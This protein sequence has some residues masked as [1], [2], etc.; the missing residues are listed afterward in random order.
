MSVVNDL[1]SMMSKGESTAFIRYLESRNKRN[2]A[3]NVKHF[4][5]VLGG[6]LTE[7][8]GAYYTQNS[9]LKSRLIEFHSAKV[10]EGEVSEEISVIKL[11][12]VARKLFKQER[13][14]SAFKLLEAAEQAALTINHF[15]LLQEIYH[16]F[17][18]NSHLEECKDRDGL[19]EKLNKNQSAIINSEKLNLAFATVKRRFREYQNQGQLINLETIVS[20]T[21][22]ELQL[23]QNLI[24]NFQSLSQLAEITDIQGAYGRS[25]HKVNLFFE[26]QIS[27]L[28]DS[29]LDT[30]KHLIYHI[31]LLYVMGSTYFRK[32]NFQKAQYYVDQLKVQMMRYNSKHYNESLPKWTLLQSLVLN[33]TGEHQQALF[34]IEECISLNYAHASEL[35]NLSLLRACI[36]F[37]QGDLKQCKKTLAMFYRSD[38]WYESKH[39]LE[40]LLNKNYMEILLYIELEDIDYADARIKSLQRNYRA[41]LKSHDDQRVLP[42]LKLVK[43]YFQSARGITKQQISS[44]LNDLS[45]WR[46]RENEDIFLMSFY[47]WLKSKNTGKP[48]YETTLGI[49]NGE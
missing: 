33:Y 48:L 27:L 1:V 35:H 28:Q 22:E 7:R 30:E 47:A 39:G 25:Y 41:K 11:L 24:Y 46:P 45:D 21:F 4:K 40:W 6:D 29:Q 14:R 49:V 26:D 12:L 5:Q 3:K 16:T 44:V 10:I 31:N 17:I 13:Y 18:E 43:S 8:K 36:Q 15:S 38:A 20:Q 9:R 2:D 34:I 23:D 19:L 37:Q 42:F 32:L